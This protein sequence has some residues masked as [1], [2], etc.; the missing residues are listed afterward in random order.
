MIYQRLSQQP[1]FR[2]P[3]DGLLYS[4]KISRDDIFKLRKQR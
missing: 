2:T 1:F 4:D 3:L